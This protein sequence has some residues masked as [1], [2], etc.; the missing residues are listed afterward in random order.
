MV[1]L[2]VVLASMQVVYNLAYWHDAHFIPLLQNFIKHDMIESFMKQYEG[3]PTTYN[4]GE[5]MS[6][7]VKIPLVFTDFYAVLKNYIVPYVLSFC[8]TA[9]VVFRLNWQM[10]IVLLLTALVIFA[11]F[12]ISP[13]ACGKASIVQEEAHANLDE[14]MDDILNNLQIIQSC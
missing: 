5:I 1:I 12:F 2:V 8:I 13:Y 6:R 10:G 4:T 14:Q 7:L 3:L 11:M 9:I